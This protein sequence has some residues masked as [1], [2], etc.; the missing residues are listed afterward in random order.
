MAVLERRVTAYLRVMLAQ[1]KKVGLA[2]WRCD[3]LFS[4]MV[5]DDTRNRLQLAATT[6]F[7][8]SEAARVSCSG[9]SIAQGFQS[10]FPEGLVKPDF[11][12]LAER[13]IVAL[14]R[15]FPHMP[16]TT[17]SVIL[18]GFGFHCSQMDVSDVYAS[19]GLSR[20][21][22]A[23]AEDNDF[24]D[25]NRRA[26]RLSEILEMDDPDA[27]EP[28]T[29]RFKWLIKWLAAARGSRES[30]LTS[31]PIKRA[32]FFYWWKSFERAGM[33]GLVEP[34]RELFRNSKI[35]PGNEARLVIDKL[36]HPE[37]TDGFYVQRLKSMGIR[38]KRD[39]IAKVFAH[40]RISE[41]SSAFI[42]NLQRLE[43]PEA[44]IECSDSSPCPD[45]VRQV[46]E[47]FAHMWEGLL[48][49]SFRTASP[50]LFALWAYIEELG[51]LPLLD[52]MGLSKPAQKGGYSWTDMMLFDIARRF[53][54]VS[55]DSAACETEMPELAYFAHLLK[56]PCND[57]L[58]SGL[59]R[60]TQPQTFKLRQW[61][62]QQLASLGLATGRQI[63]FDFHQIDQDVILPSLRQFGKG[64]SPLKKICYTGFRP[65]IAWDIEKG[66]LL[67]AEFRKSS[68]RGPTTIRRFIG[69]HI[70]PTFRNLF[71]TVYID[72]EYTGRDVWSFILDKE[73]G[74]GANLVACLKQNSLVR[75][76]RDKHLLLHEASDGFWRYYDD[77]HVFGR[78]TFELQW[79]FAHPQSHKTTVMKLKCAVKKNVRSGKLRCFG[80]SKLQAEAA[81]IFEDYTHRWTI[82][83]GI[84]DLIQSYF[85]DKCPGENPHAVDVHFLIT[86]ICRALFRMVERDAVELTRNADGSAKT[87]ARMRDTL[88]RQGAGTLHIDNGKLAV[89]LTRSY[90]PEL[91]QGLRTWFDTIEKRHQQGLNILGG[92]TL[93][94]DLSPPHGPEFKNAGRKKPIAL[95]N[96]SEPV[97]QK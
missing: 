11:D 48:K 7:R 82:E 84:K 40:W 59:R 51:V 27:I 24:M 38:I 65:H 12:R 57:T 3:P 67:A 70:L 76:A 32:T 44:V 20:D 58:L 1:A 62:V 15:G 81:D 66:T 9:H 72:S 88:F 61:L 71:D 14:K 26:S 34:G 28:L 49:H 52:S 56:S 91:T 21:T 5:D 33:L 64:P 10:G 36:Q 37:R 95:T 93:R 39:A 4:L 85:L 73:S 83:N 43:A 8:G 16:A 69:E 42:S 31:M 54:G 41:Y 77:D 22:R 6:F 75:K 92:L 35:G 23:L 97:I 50:G 45:V 86:T 29:E 87:L 55:T 60:I 68:A 30:V 13:R 90:S 2:P 19:Y 79:D 18:T 78:E 96:I 94:F 89:A 74:I 47:N 80:T 53:F 63:A 46:D 17:A 25:M